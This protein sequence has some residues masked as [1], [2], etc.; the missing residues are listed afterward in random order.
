M[1]HLA[2]LALA[3]DETPLLLGAILGD[4]VKGRLK[5]DFSAAIE[6]GIRLHRAIDAYTDQHP[7]VS[8]CL[9][10]MSPRFRRYGGIMIDVQFDYFLANS[11]E[12]YHDQSLASFSLEA[13]GK[14]A[15]HSEELPAPASQQVQ[16]MH[17]RNSLAHHGTEAYLE[18]SLIHLSTR[19]KHANPLAEAYAECRRLEQQVRRDF[20]NF[21]PDLVSYVGDWKTQH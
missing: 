16:R 3:G 12:R 1:N 19:L 21:Y 20:E 8:A 5:G 4:H 9:S 18:N 13:L 17:Q 2:H 6:R 10:R 15:A 7:R 11:F 14:I